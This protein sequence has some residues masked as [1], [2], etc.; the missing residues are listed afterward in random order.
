MPEELE[1]DPIEE[2]KKLLESSGEEVAKLFGPALTIYAGQTATSKDDKQKLG[3][4][5]RIIVGR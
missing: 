5:E 3:E 1:E 4:L 2:L